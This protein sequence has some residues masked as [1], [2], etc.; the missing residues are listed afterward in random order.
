MAIVLCVEPRWVSPYVF[1]CFV[2][3]VEKE[4]SFDV[5]ELDSGKGETKTP[6]YL[7]ETVT[8]RVPTLIHD[9]FGIGESSAIVEYLEEAFPERK[10]LPR[11]LQE[12][13]RFRQLASWI[14]SDETA[15]IRAE[16]SATTI[17]YE[18]ARSGLAPLSQEAQAAATKLFGVMT[19]LRIPERPTIFDGWT[20]LD[21]EIAFLLQRLVAN[22]ESVPDGLAA[23]ARQQWKRP[24]VQRFVTH[25]RPEIRG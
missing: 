2:T 19:R 12:R 11:S 24:S 9:A 6:A 21:A 25:A 23:W 1:A 16:R 3:L 13:A 7:A 4:T 5:R 17:F 22:G 14:R 10:V 18:S 20:I 8:G 15:S